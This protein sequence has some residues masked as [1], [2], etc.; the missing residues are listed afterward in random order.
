MQTEPI[1]ERSYSPQETRRQYARVAWFYDLWGRLTE[2][3]AVDRLLELAEVEDGCAVLEVAVGTGRLF[4]RLVEKNPAGR[5]EG[6]DLSSD[7]MDHARRR[8]ARSPSAKAGHLMQG[9]AYALPFEDAGFDYLFNTYLVDLL[10]AADQLC[11]LGEF[12]RVLKPGGRLAIAVF[13]FGEK[14]VNRFWYWIAKHFPELLTGC[15]P[16]DVTPT[17]RHLGF[18]I[19]HQEEISQNTFPS[20]IVIAEKPR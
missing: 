7:M 17:L 14:R 6:I 9:N 12:R 18:R 16:V 11:V 13:S 2:D 10:P 4:A 3:K 15:R 19:L 1:L 20:T 8:L 5:N